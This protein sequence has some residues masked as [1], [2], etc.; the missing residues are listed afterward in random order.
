VALEIE[1]AFLDLYKLSQEG[2]LTTNY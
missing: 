2:L 1:V